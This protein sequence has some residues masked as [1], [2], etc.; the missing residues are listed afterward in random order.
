MAVENPWKKG[1]GVGKKGKEKIPEFSE[2]VMAQFGADISYFSSGMVSSVI[3]DTLMLDIWLRVKRGKEGN[4]DVIFSKVGEVDSNSF[5]PFGS[6]PD[7]MVMPKDNGLK[8][9]L[10]SLPKDF[11]PKPILAVWKPVGVKLNGPASKPKTQ[12]LKFVMRPEACP[13]KVPTQPK[14]SGNIPS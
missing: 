14:V 8:P 12:L 5:K 13:Q 1:G 6:K 11:G 7:I 9:K 2:K 10:F 4:W 3:K